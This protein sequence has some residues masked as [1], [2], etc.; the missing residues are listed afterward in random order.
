M[1]EFF[2]KLG[3]TPED[4]FLRHIRVNSLEFALREAE[5][6]HLSAGQFDLLK[7]ANQIFC[8]LDQGIAPED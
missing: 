3:H 8:Y 1:P 7:R 4:N 2:E 5:T 6:F